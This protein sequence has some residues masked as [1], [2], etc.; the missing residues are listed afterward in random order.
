MRYRHMRSS[1]ADAS[2]AAAS[3][4][5]VP[6]AYLSPFVVVIVAQTLMLSVLFETVSLSLGQK[7]LA[8]VGSGVIV[9]GI[10]VGIWRL[11]V[12]PRR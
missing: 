10:M 1:A 9:G 3:T 12:G 8:G 2:N 7:L 5:G 4:E 6:R 11:F